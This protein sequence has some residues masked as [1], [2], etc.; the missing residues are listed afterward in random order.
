MTQYH[1]V[2]ETVY[3]LRWKST[4]AR[5]KADDATKYDYFDVT[6]TWLCSSNTVTLGNTGIG[7]VDTTYE[8]GSGD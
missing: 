7:L 2:L 4:D 5:S 6:I 1:S 3:N 8:L